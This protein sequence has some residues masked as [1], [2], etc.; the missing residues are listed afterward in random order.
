MKYI[1]L[2]F[3]LVAI[4]TVGCA[5][6][7]N[8]LHREAMGGC[9]KLIVEPNGIVRKPTE[10]EKS[11]QCAS[12]WKAYNKRLESNAKREAELEAAEAGRCPRGT[13]KWCNAHMR[14]KKCSCIDDWEIRHMLERLG[15][16]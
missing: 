9:E 13:T 7:T 12:A 1:P 2:L 3:V 10:Q 11:D 16:Y 6:S 15:V 4:G 5:T 8:D 14:T